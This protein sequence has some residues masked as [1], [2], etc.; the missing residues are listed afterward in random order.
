MEEDR[1]L[2]KF[3]EE[4]NDAQANSTDFKLD[5]ILNDNLRHLQASVAELDSE[6]R[7]SRSEI[8]RVRDMAK[9]I[10]RHHRIPIASL[11]G[12][13]TPSVA[14]SPVSEIGTPFDSP[15]VLR[16]PPEVPQRQNLT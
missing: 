16:P 11:G 1:A 14:L 10:C 13:G 15:F 5:K 3:L 2:H 7:S 4:T 12:V 6:L 9:N 8:R